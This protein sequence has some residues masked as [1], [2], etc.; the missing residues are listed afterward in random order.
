MGYDKKLVVQYCYY[1]M[2]SS[3]FKS[4]SVANT[5]VEGALFMHFKEA[6]NDFQYSCEDVAIQSIEN[7]LPALINNIDIGALDATIKLSREDDTISIDAGDVSFDVLCGYAKGVPVL[8]YNNI[9]IKKKKRGR[10]PKK[11]S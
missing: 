5:L 4:Y 10:K 11:E 3:Y 9:V 8:T 6:G 2:I 7:E 1:E